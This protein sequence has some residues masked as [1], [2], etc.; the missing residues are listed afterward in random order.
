[1]EVFGGLPGKVNVKLDGVLFELDNGDGLYGGLHK[2]AEQVNAGE[3]PPTE[4]EVEV[5][6][7]PFPAEASKVTRK[8][9][10]P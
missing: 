5:V 3:L 6:A 7:D 8:S 9:V 1:M 4:P 2:F 10:K